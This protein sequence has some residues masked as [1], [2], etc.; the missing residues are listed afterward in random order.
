M[1]RGYDNSRD[2]SLQFHTIFLC[3]RS[4]RH[5]ALIV[6]HRQH[7]IEIEIERITEEGIGKIGTKGLDATLFELINSRFDHLFLFISH[8]RIQREDGQTGIRDAEVA[9]E[10]GMENAPLIDNL[11]SGDSLSHILDGQMSRHEANTHMFADHHRESLLLT[12]R[13]SSRHHRS[14]HQHV[15]KPF[16]KVFLR[17]RHRLASSLSRLLRRLSEFHFYLIRDCCQQIHFV[18]LGILCAI[19][20]AELRLYPHCLTMSGGHLG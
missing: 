7:A 19:D 17:F 5:G 12:N 2:A 16:L 13:T 8:L 20:H 6:V 10:T 15:V 1:V 14:S 3:N 9:T 18:I 4:E 11:L